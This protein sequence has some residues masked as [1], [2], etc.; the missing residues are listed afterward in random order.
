MEQ[1]PIQ[2]LLNR[3]EGYDLL[4]LKEFLDK[5]GPLTNLQDSYHGQKILLKPNLISGRGPALSC[6]NIIVIQAVAEWFLDRGAEV[7]IGDSP[8]FGRALQVIKQQGMLPVVNRLNLKVVEFQTPV[9]HNLSHDT[10]VGI[11]AECLNYDLLVNLPKVK[12]HNQMFMTLAVKNLFGIVCGMRK[13][14]AHMKNG[15]SHMK[16]ADL[17]LDLVEVIPKSV[18]IAD[19]IE[20]M[21]REGPLGGDL[22]NL[23]C[24]AASPD[25]VAL[26][27]AMLE[28]LELD[29]SMCPIWKAAERRGLPGSKLGN[30]DFCFESPEV[31]YGSG[32]V[33]PILLNPVPF[34]PL[35]FIH[36]SIKKMLL[37]V[38]D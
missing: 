26:D 20:A 4:A 17:M 18:T 11:A 24:V 25:P 16:F 3:I 6:T 34:N 19:G 30:L 10:S 35:R 12:A 2:L 5:S 1:R 23:G 9:V 32:F 27:T 13:A 21:H 7:A 29:N 37:R 22:L 36:S 15:S 8:A 14:V 33:A 28:L 38:R 31:F